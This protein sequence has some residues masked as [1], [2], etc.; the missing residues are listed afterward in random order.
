MTILAAAAEG[1]VVSDTACNI[2]SDLSQLPDRTEVHQTVMCQRPPAMD[3]SGP[4]VSA[5]SLTARSTNLTEDDAVDSQSGR[6][7]SAAALAPMFSFSVVGPP[8]AY[9]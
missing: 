1:H 7:S 2:G 8:P 9:S 5:V 6:F 3:L 4:K